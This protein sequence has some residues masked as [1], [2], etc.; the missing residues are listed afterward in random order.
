MVKSV[1]QSM[2]FA[3]TPIASVGL[4]EQYLLSLHRTAK[5]VVHNQDRPE[6]STQKTDSVFTRDTRPLG[7]LRYNGFPGYCFVLGSG[8][9][10]MALVEARIWETDV[11]D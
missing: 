3:D 7:D 1:S 10:G 6:P 2:S 9:Y 4:S 8:F 5:C 11:D